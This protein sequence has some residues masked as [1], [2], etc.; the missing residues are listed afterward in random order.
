MS[1]M[2]DGSNMRLLHQHDPEEPTVVMGPTPTGD[3]LEELVDLGPEMFS[4]VSGTVISY[5]G[6]N[7][8]KACGAF[9]R[10]NEQGGTSSC[11]MP[12]RFEH[13]VHM[14]YRGNTTDGEAGVLVSFTAVP[15][16]QEELETVSRSLCR[17]FE[18]LTSHGIQASMYMTPGGG[19]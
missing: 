12:V 18:V 19:S 8:Y 17:A 11:V 13:D 7:Y 2:N 4:D 9:V 15:R 6:E 5:Q 14:D 10:N 1:E 16:D 3:G